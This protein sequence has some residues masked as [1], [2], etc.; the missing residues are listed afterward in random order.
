M[1]VCAVG[2]GG[3]AKLYPVSP[4]YWI[5]VDVFLPWM[6]ILPVGKTRG[7]CATSWH[8]ALPS[9]LCHPL[10]SVTLCPHS[11]FSFQ[12]PSFNPSLSLRLEMRLN[13]TKT[14]CS[15]RIGRV[16]ESSS[17]QCDARYVLIWTLCRAARARLCLYL[18]KWKRGKQQEKVVGSIFGLG[19]LMWFL[20]NKQS[21]LW[22]WLWSRGRKLGSWYSLWNLS[23]LMCI[24]Y[25][26]IDL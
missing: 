5:V 26:P 1:W 10:P 6:I 21:W 19:V 12:L 18:Y 4:G 16:R 15:I 25:K 11:S 7:C 20:S 2:G 14:Q 8:S 13:N 17:A 23:V 9:F 3:G 22:G 24:D